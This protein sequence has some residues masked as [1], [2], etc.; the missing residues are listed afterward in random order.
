MTEVSRE[1]SS[2]KTSQKTRRSGP[3]EPSDEV[4]TARTDRLRTE[5]NELCGRDGSQRRTGRGS[6][7]QPHPEGPLL[8]P[9]SLPHPDFVVRPLTSGI[10]HDFVEEHYE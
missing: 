9:N 2:Q 7:A 6:F 1:R 8:L 3:P 10:N 4:A 5:R